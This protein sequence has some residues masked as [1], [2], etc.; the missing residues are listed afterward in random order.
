MKK[1][2]VVL[3]CFIWVFQS[4]SQT[5]TKTYG[6]IDVEIIKEKH[7]KKIFAK[8]KIKRAFAGGDSIWIQ[9]IEES[10]NQSI[11]YKNGAKHGKYIVSVRFIVKP[12]GTLD[13]FACETSIGFGMEA[14]VIR[15]LRKR[16]PSKWVAKP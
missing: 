2:H 9:S 3:L 14:E 11:L 4:Y 1:F 8:V 12:D 13:E 15:V 16:Y 7:A 10:I 5:N 6:R